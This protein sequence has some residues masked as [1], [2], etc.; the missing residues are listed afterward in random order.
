MAALQKL[1]AIFGEHTTNTHATDEA[2]TQT[3][4]TPTTP[5]AIRKAP[6]VHGQTTRNNK[7]GFIPLTTEGEHAGTREDEEIE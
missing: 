1:T 6:R 7:P 5:A 3:S 4:N 2:I